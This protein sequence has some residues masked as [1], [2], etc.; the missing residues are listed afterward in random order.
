MTATHPL[1]IFDR[2]FGDFADVSIAVSIPFEQEELWGRITGG[3][4]LHS[5]QSE[6]DETQ[7][8]YYYPPNQ[9]GERINALMAFVLQVDGAS[10]RLPATE[11]GREIA[12]QTPNH[13]TSDLKRHGKLLPT[14]WATKE[15]K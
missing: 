10:I 1:D 15:N 6:S 4:G 5:E 13:L 8:T 7:I 14:L 12:L 9:G 11:R 3:N 2:V